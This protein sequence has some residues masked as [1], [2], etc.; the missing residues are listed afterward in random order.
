L[1][2]LASCLNAGEQPPGLCLE[3]LKRLAAGHDVGLG[4]VAVGLEDEGGQVEQIG[5]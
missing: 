4:Q 2:G 1:D 3:G 5:G